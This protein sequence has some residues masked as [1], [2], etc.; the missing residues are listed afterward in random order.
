MWWPHEPSGELVFWPSGRYDYTSVCLR[1]NPPGTIVSPG[2]SHRLPAAVFRGLKACRFGL[3]DGQGEISAKRFEIPSA[4]E[5]RGVRR[6]GRTSPPRLAPGGNG[7]RGAVALL[8]QADCAANPTSTHQA[9]R[10]EFQ[11]IRARSWLLAGPLSRPIRDPML[12]G[13]VISRPYGP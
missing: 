9:E 2:R 8:P 5:R 11:V 12:R 7:K 10:L 1:S 3:R 4:G 6:V 13:R